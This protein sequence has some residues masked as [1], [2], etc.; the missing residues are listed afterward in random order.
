MARIHLFGAAENPL[1]AILT[2]IERALAAKFYYLSIAVSLTLPDICSSLEQETSAAWV[3]E[4]TFV[5]WCDQYF[6]D[7]YPTLTALDFYQLRGGVLHRAE[8][9]GHKKFRFTR[10][11]FTLPDGRGTV[12]DQ[13]MMGM[14]EEVAINLD[15]ALFCNN[16][17]DAA[18]KWYLAHTED[19]VVR[20][21][22]PNL[23]RYRP[24]GL[25][26]FIVGLPLIA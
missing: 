4:K 20:E 1:D 6:M 8:F 26:P 11:L 3:N 9:A 24:D 2:D 5:A 14:G 12:A 10:V 19:L 18:R 13:N 25:A 21:N 23:V 15:A 22:L 16:M 17:I 7:S